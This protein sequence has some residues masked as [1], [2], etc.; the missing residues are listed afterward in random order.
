VNVVLKYMLVI[1]LIPLFGD[2]LPFYT[3]CIKY[4][5]YR[6]KSKLTDFNARS[7]I[8]IVAVILV[9]VGIVGTLVFIYCVESPESTEY[10]TCCEKYSLKT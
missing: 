10:R 2:H 7:K 9:T 1:D 3:L 4:Y 6:V 5:I 8:G